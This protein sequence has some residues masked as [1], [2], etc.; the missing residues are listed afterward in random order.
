DPEV[1][2]LGVEVC[3][4][5]LIGEHDTGAPSKRRS[6]EKLAPYLPDSVSIPESLLNIL[7][8]GVASYGP[9]KAHRDAYVRF[10]AKL[11]RTA[12]ARVA[13]EGA[14]SLD[15]PWAF[16]EVVSSV[17]TST[18]QLQANAVLHGCFPD[19]FDVMISNGHRV[20]VLRA[21][22][23]VSGVG[24]ATNQDRAMIAVRSL[25]E[26]G[27]PRPIR[28]IYAPGFRE[29]WDRGRAPEWEQLTNAVV[30]SLA[31]RGVQRAA[32]VD[33]FP[34]PDPTI[35]ARAQEV[36]GDDS[37]HEWDELLTEA[38]G[39]V[40]AQGQT[41]GSWDDFLPAFSSALS[42]AAAVASAEVPDA[43]P[44][45]VAAT[46]LPPSTAT[47]A[48]RL[49]LRQSWLQD[50][51]DLLERRRQVIFY[52]PPGT[53]KTFV[54]RAI[55]R[56]IAPDPGA[57]QVVQF[58]PSYAYEDFIEGYRPVKTASGGLAY[59][60]VP[61]P[62]REIAELARASP[63]RPFVL[64]IDEIN[65]GNIPKIFGELYFLLEYRDEAMRLQYST[66]ET[67]S[68]PPNLHVIGTMNTADRSIALLD[69][70]LRRRFGFVELS[71]LCAP[72]D[73]LLERWLARHGLDPEPGTLLSTLN[74]MLV[75]ADGDTDLAIGP[76][77]F[78][79]TDEIDPEL[80]KIWAHDLLPMLVDRFHGSG[81]RVEQEFG[82]ERVRSEAAKNADTGDLEAS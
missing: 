7:D 73:G 55:A 43:V 70:A 68:L 72:V 78:M 21:F 76:S 75:D 4:V 8:S 51:I 13:E 34:S 11:G 61:G 58:H 36:L 46:A 1:R 27:L 28:D 79:S 26:E 66:S 3:F 52:G 14:A 74:Q 10:L 81:R 16:R 69:A 2:Q 18:D 25:A 35:M 54:A 38:T 48:S 80:E 19:V 29:V 47:L 77:F 60:L 6:L 64:L 15:D 37:P 9:G 23:A 30:R 24:D 31:D 5:E 67:F 59:D 62:L 49:L 17:R 53:G 71:P 41:P 40:A 65:R 56:H 50:T 20:K 44:H 57:V 32:P 12:K 82:L 42:D 63:G 39:R 22:Q 45:E 33:A